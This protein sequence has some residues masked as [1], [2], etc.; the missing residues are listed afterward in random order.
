MQ[1]WIRKKVFYSEKKKKQAILLIW[2]IL[3]LRN[4]KFKGWEMD[5]NFILG[6]GNNRLRESIGSKIIS[7]SKNLLIIITQIHSFLNQL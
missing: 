1:L 3:D 2:N 7:L 4:P 5:L 6:I